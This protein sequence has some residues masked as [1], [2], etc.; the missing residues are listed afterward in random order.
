M[1]NLLIVK[2]YNLTISRPKRGTFTKCINVVACKT[3]MSYEENIPATSE[4]ELNEETGE[5]AN[6][7]KHRNCYQFATPVQRSVC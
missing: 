7:L 1:I 6:R 4:Q 5:Q 2:G 3:S